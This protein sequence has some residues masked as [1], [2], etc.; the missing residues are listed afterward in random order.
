[1]YE[2]FEICFH[3][4]RFFAAIKSHWNQCVIKESTSTV[5]L[6]LSYRNGLF[7]LIGCHLNLCFCFVLFALFSHR[8]AA[9]DQ[10]LCLDDLQQDNE[11]PYNLGLYTCHRPNVTRSQFFTL[12]DSGVV[13]NELSCASVQQRYVSLANANKYSNN[14]F[15]W[16]KFFV[17]FSSN[18]CS[19]S[20]KNNVVMASCLDN[21]AYNEKWEVTPFDQI[22]NVNLD[23]C[24][25]YANLNA[26]DHVFAQKCNTQSETQKWIIE[27]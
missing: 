17:S 15:I 8:F 2:T 26:Q 3:S 23:L 16:S 24:L 14:R 13:R 11:K 25:D 7:M 19:Y 5:L 6:A 9:K 27:H 12:T 22:R 10:N 4:W 21:D 20:K 1:M 18:I